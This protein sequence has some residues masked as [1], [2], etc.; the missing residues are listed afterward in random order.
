MKVEKKGICFLWLL[1][2]SVQHYILAPFYISWLKWCS[3]FGITWLRITN[4][5]GQEE[6]GSLSSSNNDTNS[7][8]T[9]S[10]KGSGTHTQKHVWYRTHVCT[11]WC[12]TGMYGNLFVS[13]LLL[14]NSIIILINKYSTG[15]SYI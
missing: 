15:H 9:C 7:I 13:I 14:R 12:W 11:K 4:R 2:S 3:R 1:F 6:E 10:I 5:E 8:I